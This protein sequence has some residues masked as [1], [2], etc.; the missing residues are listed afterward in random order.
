MSE[1]IAFL[2]LAAVNVAAFLLYNIRT[3]KLLSK[4]RRELKKEVDGV[5][6]RIESRLVNDVP[7]FENIAGGS[8]TWGVMFTFDRKEMTAHTIRTLREHEPELPLLVVD[9]GSTDG[10][11]EMLTHMHRE[12][13]LQKV[14]LNRHND[15]PQWQKAFALK[16]ALKILAMEFPAY[17]V[18]LDDDLEIIRP[19]VKEAIGLFDAL[20]DQKVKV[21]NMTDDEIEERNHPTIKKVNVMVDGLSEEIKIRATFNGQ[22]NIIPTGFFHETGYPPIAEGIS[23]LASEDWFYSRQC[24]IRGYHVAV[25]QAAN[26]LGVG[27]NSKR[28][29]I[30]RRIA[31]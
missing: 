25:F 12:G 30:E 18:W 7:D 13:K 29:E 26:H 3:K 21:I 20:R 22:F 8:S 27:K 2:I 9:N 23:E 28:V 16:Q 15:V 6:R 11:A 10:T 5:F 19:F 14:L 17:I 1:P 24:Q 31:T 4:Y